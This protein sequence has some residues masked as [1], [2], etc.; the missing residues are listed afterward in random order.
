MVGHL[1]RPQSLPSQGDAVIVESSDI[2]ILSSTDRL[3]RALL[4]WVDICGLS[5]QF[6]AQSDVV[7]ALASHDLLD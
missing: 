3:Q 5:G 1:T 4:R 7:D 2:P 6:M